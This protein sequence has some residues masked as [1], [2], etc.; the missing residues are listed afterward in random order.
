SSD[1]IVVI[2]DQGDTREESPFHERILG[3]GPEE[4]T[5]TV[6]DR[7]HPGD[8]SREASDMVE[9]LKHPG[10]I[11]CTE[12][13]ARHKDGSWH[14]LEARGKNLLH[15][16][17]VQGIIVNVRDITES[18]LAERALAESERKYRQLVETLHE[19][20]WA[21]DKDG[22]TTFVNPRMAEMLGYTVAEM[23]GRPLFAFMDERGIE[24]AGRLLERRQAGIKEEHEFEFMRKD[25]VRLCALME[26]SPLLDDDGKYSGAIAA[27][28]DITERKRAEEE[29]QRR[30][31]YF[32]ALIENSEDAFIV[33]D[34]NGTTHDENTN[35]ERMLGYGPGE[36]GRGNYEHFHPDDVPRAA[37]EL[38]ELLKLPGGVSCTEVRIQHKNGSWRYVDI[39]GKNLLHDPAVKGVV[40]N[41]SDITE[42]KRVEEALRHSEERFKALAE[43]T[44][45]WIWEVDASGVYTYASPKVRDLL[46]YE[47]EQV[48]GKTPFDFMPPEEAR[49]IAPEFQA[50]VDGRRP[51]GALENACLHKDGRLLV[52]ETSGVPFFDAEGVLCGYRGIDRDVTERKKAAEALKESERLYRIVTDNITDVICYA[53]MNLKATYYSPSVTRLLG[54]S[55][56]EAMTLT[57]DQVM[58]PASR[59]ASL[60]GLAR[61]M[62][63]R[64]EG[65]LDD[66]TP[67]ELDMELRRKDGSTVWV[68]ASLSFVKDA[69]GQPAGNVTVWRDISIRKKAQDALRASEER[70]R[71][72][73]ENMSDV[74][75]TVDTRSRY[76]YMSPSVTRV[77]GYSVAEAL[78]Q[79]PEEEFPPGSREAAADLMSEIRAAAQAGTKDRPQTWTAD[80]EVTCKNGSTIWMETKIA[81]MLG[82]DGEIIGYLGASR[83]ITERR[84]ADKERERLNAELIEKNNE[85]E[86][87][88]YVTSHDLRS[89]LVNVEGFT[90][91]LDYSLQELTGVVKDAEI[92]AELR[93]RLMP[94]LEKDVPEAMGYILTSVS[95]MDTL[96]IGLLRLSRAGRTAPVLERLDMNQLLSDSAKAHE[97]RIRDK[98]V[99]LDI[100]VLPSCLGDAGQISQVFSN[101]LDN[102]LKYLD[103][104]RKGIIG[105]TGRR[106]ED[107]VVYCVADNGIG[108][109]AQHQ[110]RI[111]E[112]FYQL[113][114][115]TS[116]GEGLGLSIVKKILSRHGGRIWVESEPGVGSKFYVLL[117]GGRHDGEGG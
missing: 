6:F 31:R 109:A 16:P 4:Q 18:K 85:L 54:Y 65:R 13:R 68:Q 99:N 69:N 41:M 113:N 103:P 47:P 94:I 48:I 25:G 43:N 104:N 86:Q 12:V 39:H 11:S 61:V 7:V 63:A 28:A 29:L 98:G 42:R 97:F 102:A 111:F 71:L 49:R 20:I 112:I 108:I 57:A 32:R 76:T 81:P 15:D 2:D 73:A 115:G 72:L 17:A 90:K 1:A 38:A 46:G 82:G 27:V 84:R 89:P 66:S 53:D 74:V 8:V 80:L 64:R 51:F 36:Q 79:G 116:G 19:G 114:P 50:I 62:A 56:E 83:D 107:R 59:D 96:L 45:D 23:Q 52:L 75:W 95:K 60:K 24:I 5:K 58:T 44:S 55:V 30:E 21:I 77:R 14:W 40:V 91:E 88:I 35:Y 10:G 3:Y 22:C 100:G 70:Y 110:E 78:A 106:D 37:G 105:I 101:L 67:L 34:E 87:I 33:V 92:P 9:L 26:T 93:Q 117:P